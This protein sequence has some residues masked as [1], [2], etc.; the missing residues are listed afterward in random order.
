MTTISGVRKLADV[1]SVELHVNAGNGSSRF[2]RA[3]FTKDRTA[4]ALPVSNEPLKSPILTVVATVEAVVVVVA[5]ELFVVGEVGV[6]GFFVV[7]AVEED[8]VVGAIEVVRSVEGIEVS[9]AE[10]SVGS[11]RVVMEESDSV[12]L[13]DAGGSVESDSLSAVIVGSFSAEVSE[14]LA[15]EGLSSPSLLLASFKKSLDA[16]LQTKTVRDTVTS[17][18]ST[19]SASAFLWAVSQFAKLL[20]VIIIPR[21]RVPT[22]S[23]QGAVGNT[24]FIYY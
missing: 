8:A 3:S 20:C 9:D 11:L 18:A 15:S 23:K 24:F 22:C 21:L 1:T 6:V 13:P 7:A 10:V 4:S 14:K 12:T 5:E 17:S 19:M 2:A 16:S